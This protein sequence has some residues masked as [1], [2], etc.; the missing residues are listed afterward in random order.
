MIDKDEVREI[1]ESLDGDQ[2]L[3]VNDEL[4]QALGIEGWNRHGDAKQVF[5]HPTEVSEAWVAMGLHE[6]DDDEVEPLKIMAV[7]DS[8]DL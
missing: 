3:I 7:S 2:Y 1:A 8:V 4:S 5:N 6:L